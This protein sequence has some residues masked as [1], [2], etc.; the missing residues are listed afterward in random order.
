VFALFYQCRRFEP[1][2]LHAGRQVG[3]TLFDI[4]AGGYFSGHIAEQVLGRPGQKHCY[5]RV[6]Y[7]PVVVEGDFAKATTLL[8][9]GYCGTPEY[10]LILR[11]SLDNAARTRLISTASDM[12]RGILEQTGDFTLTKWFHDNGVAQIIETD[13]DFYF[14]R[15]MKSPTQNVVDQSH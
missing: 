5:Y 9:P 14:P 2:E 1:C 8:Y 3:F 4:S 12:S 7:C 6:G 15:I 11:S 10:G 13:E